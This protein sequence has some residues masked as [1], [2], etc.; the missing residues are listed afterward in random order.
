[1]LPY[2]FGSLSKHHFFST[3]K[4]L[5]PVTRPVSRGP[6]IHSRDLTLGFCVMGISTMIPQYPKQ[7]LIDH[8]NNLFYRRDRFRPISEDVQHSSAFV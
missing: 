5:G 1:M 8:E 6:D 2:G 3:Y 7:I 4:K